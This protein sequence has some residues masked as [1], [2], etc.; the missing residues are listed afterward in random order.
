MGCMAGLDNLRGKRQIRAYGDVQP[1]RTVRF[2]ERLRWSAWPCRKRT[3]LNVNTLG[4]N[5]G[6]CGLVW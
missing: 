2:S 6:C 4:M 5:R 3:G 1:G